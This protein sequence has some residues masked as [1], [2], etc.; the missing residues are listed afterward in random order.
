MQPDD[1]RHGRP[2]GYDA[3]CREACCRAAA[4]AYVRQLRYDNILGRPPRTVPGIGAQR[5]VQALVAIGYT[6]RDISERLGLGHDRA[7]QIAVLERKYIRTT[8]AENVRNL[9]DALSMTPA[10]DGWH[11]SYA[12]AVA[13]RNGWAPPLAWDDIDNPDENPR[14]L[15]AS[16]SNDV[17]V[18]AIK[19]ARIVDGEFALKA[20][21]AEKTEVIRRWTAQGRSLAELERH[22]G[23]NANRYRPG[24]E[25]A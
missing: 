7:R 16:D 9:Y 21:P 10:P 6:F 3:G 4:A 17:A 13:R 23:W 11:A 25:V 15:R 18:D 19:V 20:T 8:T 1:P 24:K 12:R 5:R 22:T 2:A 14:G